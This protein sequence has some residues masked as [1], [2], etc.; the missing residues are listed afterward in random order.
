MDKGFEGPK[1]SEAPVY[2]PSVEYKCEP[3]GWS[4]TRVE[5]CAC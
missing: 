5:V 2:S 4:R 1:Q 3:V